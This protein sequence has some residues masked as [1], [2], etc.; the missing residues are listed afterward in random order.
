MCKVIATIVAM[1]AIG[2]VSLANV[3]RA[4]SVLFVSTGH[5]GAQVQCD[6]DRTQYW[7]MTVDS[8]VQDVVGGLFDM[9]KGS[10]TSADCTL[11]IYDGSYGS[12]PSTPLLPV[13][14]PPGSFTQQFTDIP[15]AA[16]QLPCLPG[17]PI[18]PCSPRLSFWQL[19]F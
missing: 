12:L 9:K 18:L 8:N 16:P 5:T 1:T 2:L 3:A 4:D 11:A 6:I 14:L 19:A 17:I 13:T 7:S 10:H 15:F